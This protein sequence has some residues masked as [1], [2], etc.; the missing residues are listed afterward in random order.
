MV[1]VTN[2]KERLLKVEGGHK[3]DMQNML[4]RGEYCVCCA[5]KLKK[6]SEV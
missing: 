2:A 5:G 3:R 4:I 1:E 6:T